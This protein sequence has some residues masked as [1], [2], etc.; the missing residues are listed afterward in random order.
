MYDTDKKN[1][2]ILDLNYKKFNKEDINWEIYSREVLDSIELIEE[3]DEELN[4][5]KI[6]INPF[7]EDL[8]LSYTVNK[9]DEPTLEKENIES[10]DYFR[11]KDLQKVAEYYEIPYKGKTKNKLIEKIIEF[12]EKEENCMKVYDREVNWN[13]MN[14]LSKDK[15]F[16]K[17]IINWNN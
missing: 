15:F 12:E 13:M 1:N 6:G 5:D 2:I 17:F 11:L 3:F 4:K 14:N 10:W 7:I 16:S 8:S 9:E